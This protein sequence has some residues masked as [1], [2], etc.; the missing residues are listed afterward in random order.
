VPDFWLA[1]LGTAWLVTLVASGVVVRT[2]WRTSGFL[3]QRVRP[4]APVLGVLAGTTF[5]FADLDRVLAVGVVGGSL[6]WLVVEVIE[7]GRTDC[8]GRIRR[9]VDRRRRVAVIVAAVS[10]VAMGLRFNVTGV[11]GAN[12]LVTVALVVVGSSPWRSAQARSGLLLGWSAVIVGGVFLVAGLGHQFGTAA[13]AAGVLGASLGC[14]PLLVSSLS[15][16][17]RVPAVEVLGFFTVVVALDARPLPIAPGADVVALLFLAL[18]LADVFVTR[19]AR[20]QLGSDTACESGLVERW[21]IH[22]VPRLASI[23]GLI[24]LQ[25]ALAFVALLVARRILMPTVGLGVGIVVVAIVLVPALR[26]RGEH[27]GSRN[28]SRSLLL[29]AAVV[30]AGL[31]VL[32]APAAIELLRVRGVA[33]EAGAAARRGIR[34][35]HGGDAVAARFEFELAQ[36]DFASVQNQLANPLVSLGLTVPVL[37]P[38]LRA[39]RELAAIGADL[40]QTGSR[41]ATRADPQRLRIS[42][43]TVNLAEVRRLVPEVDRVVRQLGQARRRVTSIDSA[44]VVSPLGDAIDSLDHQ[45]AKAVTDGYTARSTLPLLPAIL[46]GRGTRSYLLLVQNPAESRATG[47]LIGSFGLVTATDG[48]L[49]LYAPIAPIEAL[50]ARPGDHRIL[51]APADYVT[52]YSGLHPEDLLQDANHSPDLPTVGAVIADLYRQSA[53]NRPRPDGVI[54][55]DPFAL[56]SILELTGPIRI[57]QWPVPI[58]ANNVVSVTM[59]D[60]AIAFANDPAARDDFIG[61]VAGAAWDA[62]TQG[63]LGNPVHVLRV[64]GPAVRSHH[65]AL[66]LA[67]SNEQALVRKGHADAAL[68][69]RDPT[70]VA[71]LITQ[72]AS[73][74]KLD[75]YFARTL[76]LQLHLTPTPSTH[77]VDVRE[78]FTATLENN[79]PAGGLP[80]YVIG[81][82]IQGLAAGENRT[83]ATFYSSL[84]LRSAGLDATPLPL[85]VQR[86]LGRWAYSAYLNIPAQTR[87]QLTLDLG[88]R[89]RLGAHGTFQL[90]LPSQALV[91]SDRADVTLE[92][93]PGW[94]FTQTT[95]LDVAPGGR[96]ARFQGTLDRG[97]TLSVR[98]DHSSRSLWDRLEQGR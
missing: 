37:A 77:G 76:E 19:G 40:A 22:G 72:D 78:R 63:N 96:V 34:D 33:A 58:T 88:G 5:G 26:V 10:V 89:L 28:S 62:L 52:R 39:T 23:G 82:N 84:R 18:P 68:L 42:Q 41:L 14:A 59:Y 13:V 9:A 24:A 11:G 20:R 50:D 54:V 83:F 8:L 17:I 75:L 36:R 6:L 70:D 92:L 31:V 4:L 46:G 73:N 38:N 15:T 45:L 43:A 65:L 44:F 29:A 21:R 35:V 93:P 47:G 51:H 55:I 25:G 60:S 95:N 67:R 85:Q 91:T 87:R 71:L 27:R 57:P 12:A 3:L 86:E 74:T 98:I 7:P 69:S 32:G 90:E 79:A 56:R 94:E 49:G 66:W 81:P 80:A 53:Y 97:R 16:G 2:T 64:L 48:H 1:A 61:H 30:V